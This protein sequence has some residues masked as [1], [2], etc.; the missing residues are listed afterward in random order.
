[1]RLPFELL[2][3][4]LQLFFSLLLFFRGL[5]PEVFLPLF[6]IKR[7]ERDS[8]PCGFA[9][10]PVGVICVHRVVKVI[11]SQM[12]VS[13]DERLLQALLECQGLICVL[14]CQHLVPVSSSAVAANRGYSLSL[15]DCVVLP[16]LK[17]A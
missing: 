16:R 12:S 10:L 13:H 9:L 1:L 5:N 7:I 14:I 6:L 11:P 3:L 17:A 15:N 2:L 4:V 8:Y